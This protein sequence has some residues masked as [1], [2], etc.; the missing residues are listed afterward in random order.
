MKINFLIYFKNRVKE[1]EAP[2]SPSISTACIDALV[3]E[4]RKQE[5]GYKRHALTALARALPDAACD[6]FHQLY[7]IVKQ[8]LSKVRLVIFTIVKYF[9]VLCFSRLV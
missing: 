7:E 2:L 1:N 6:R 3:A 5:A 8:I 9:S 4:S